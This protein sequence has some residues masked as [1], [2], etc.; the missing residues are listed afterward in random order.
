MCYG[1]TVPVGNETYLKWRFEAKIRQILNVLKE[2]GSGSRRKNTIQ[3]RRIRILKMCWYESV[4]EYRYCYHSP[5]AWI[6]I[7]TA[8]YDTIQIRIRILRMCRIYTVTILQ[9]GRPWDP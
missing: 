6:R 7:Q 2:P 1:L 4:E 9:C 3:I 8:K 5:I